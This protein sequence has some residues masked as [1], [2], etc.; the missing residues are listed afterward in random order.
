MKYISGPWPTNMKSVQLF[1]AARWHIQREQVLESN[2]LNLRG[3][4]KS[5]SRRRRLIG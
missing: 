5:K 3:R 2:G 1:G 4:A